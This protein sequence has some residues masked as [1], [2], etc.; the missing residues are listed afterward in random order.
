MRR[1]Q[2]ATSNTIIQTPGEVSKVIGD[3]ITVSSNFTPSLHPKA[4]VAYKPLGGTYFR[5]V[6]DKVTSA[7]ILINLRE[8]EVIFRESHRVPC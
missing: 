3:Q 8:I 2:N 6:F 1:F 7:P 4:D 5:A